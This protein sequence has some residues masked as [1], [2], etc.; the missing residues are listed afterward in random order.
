MDWKIF[1]EWNSFLLQ[2]KYKDNL[3]NKTIREFNRVLSDQNN[4]KY[5]NSNELE[6]KNNI[7]KE[8][9][10]MYGKINNLLDKIKDNY[11]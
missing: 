9:W 1:H 6:Y 2:I 3:I 5:K 10:Q 4:N 11:K 7:S 8:N